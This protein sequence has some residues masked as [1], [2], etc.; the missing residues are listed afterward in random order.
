MHGREKELLLHEELLLIALRDEKGAIHYQAG[1]C[2]YAL[3]AAILA[4][5]LL[6]ERIAVE[7]DKKRIVNVTNTRPIG[8][9]LLDECLSR[10]ESARRR[11]RLR[12][13]VQRLANT[14]QLRQRIAAGLCQ[15]GIL[16]E[17]EDRVLWLF[18]RKLFPQRDPRHERR[19]IERLRRAIFTETR[20]V[21]PRTAILIAL[22]NGSGLLRIPFDKRELRGR[23]ERLTRITEGQLLGRA[24]HDAIKAV[25]AAIVAAS[26]VASTTAVTAACT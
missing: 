22:A 1:M 25:Q 24:M 14:R 23:K 17:D 2:Q 15:R 18:R 7:D 19:I 10:I 20:S 4:E 12:A 5:L 11:Q 16:R 21:A 9:P 8:E 13:W 6:A 26:T 3:A